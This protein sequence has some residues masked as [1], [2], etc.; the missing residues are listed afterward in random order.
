MV[1]EVME[2]KAII[3]QKAGIPGLKTFLGLLVI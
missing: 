2:L 3:T 1:M